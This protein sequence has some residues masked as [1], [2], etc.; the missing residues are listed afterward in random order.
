MHPKAAIR[1]VVV[2]VIF[3]L[4]LYGNRLINNI[5][6]ISIQHSY[7]RM[8]YTYS[9]WLVPVGLATAAIFGISRVPAVLGLNH[10]P[11]KAFGFAAVV[12]SPM[13][14]SSALAG[15]VP[16]DLTVIRLIQ[17]TLLAGLMEELLFRGFLFGLLFRFC[18]WG[19]VPASLA[20]AL[21]FG[22]SH[23][24]QGSNLAEASG[25]FLVTAMGAVWFAWLYIEWD[26]NLWVPVFLH[27]LMN[28]SWTLFD[29]SSNAL[30]SVYPN[31]FR[32][33]T[34]ALS[35]IITLKSFKDRG[36]HIKKSNLLINN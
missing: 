31:I 32:I 21:V 3:L 13:L 26:N 36:M 24:Y 27:I 20:G 6:D 28:L 34:I 10:N 12:V 18:G 17:A 23:L 29:M 4:S 22:L 30:G 1:S 11:W 33:L 7:L 25:V 5:F 14:I 35:I 9:W 15:R 16:D 19:F 2:I 8:L